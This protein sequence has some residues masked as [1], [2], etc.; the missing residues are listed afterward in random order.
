MAGVTGRKIAFLATDGVEERELAEPWDALSDAG[1]DVQLISLQPGEIQGVQ[2]DNPT[3][4]FAVDR[5]I[6]QVGAGDYYG[7]V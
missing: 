1:A 3:R 6:D 7:L 5:V 4:R 2:D